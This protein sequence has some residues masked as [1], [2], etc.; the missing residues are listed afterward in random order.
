M[1]AEDNLHTTT[2]IG[3][4]SL[5]RFIHYKYMDSS[6]LEHTRWTDQILSQRVEAWLQVLLIRCQVAKTRLQQW[7]VMCST[8]NDHYLKMV[9]IKQYCASKV[10]AVC[11]AGKC[12]TCVRSYQQHDFTRQVT[13]LAIPFKHKA[14]LSGE[15]RWHFCQQMA[16]KNDH[17]DHFSPHF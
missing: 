12:S 11:S 5:D 4:W 10:S 16:W 3:K 13:F 7:S 17:N 8:T 6:L 2:D 9:H 1:T 15:E 14:G